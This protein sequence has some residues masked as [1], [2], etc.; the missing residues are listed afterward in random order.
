MANISLETTYEEA[1]EVLNFVGISQ[2]GNTAYY[3]YKEGIIVIWRDDSP[4]T[5]DVI[6]IRNSY[7]GTMDFGPWMGENRHIKMGQSFADQF[8]KGEE[9]TDILE[10][11]KARHFITSLYKH[12]ENTE[13]DCLETQS[14]SLSI[15]PEGIYVLF[16]FAKM[17]FLFGNDSRRNLVQIALIKDDDPA[18]FKSPFDMLTAQFFCE[19]EDGS[20]V[21]FGLGDSYKEVI[22]KS[23]INPDLPITYWNTLLAQQTKS[24]YIAWKRNNFE[25]KVEAIPDTTHLSLVHMGTNQYNIPFLLNQS[26]IKISLGEGN[27]VQLTLEPLAEEGT[28]WTM[29]DIS[30]KLQATEADSS[31]FYLSTEMPQIKGNI[32]VQKNL[33]KALLGLLEETYTNFYSSESSKLKIHKKIFGEYDDKFA[34]KPQGFLIISNPA[35]VPDVFLTKYPLEISFSIDEPSGRTGFAFSLVDDDFQNHMIKTPNDS[36]NFLQPVQELLGFKLGEKIY[37]RDKKPGPETAI[38]AYTVLNNHTTPKHP[39]FLHNLST[40][41]I[42]NSSKTLITLANY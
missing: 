29:Q 15:N 30:E 13:E 6:L 37:L 35:R 36:L 19:Q 33:I 3:V 34:L 17:V 9:H 5:P 31:D 12:L 16:H 7:Q 4:R 26:L 27:T 39:D 2:Q 23:G 38:V 28:Q 25:E 8:S 40:Y 41:A 24:T 32:T 42:P 18:C 22:E 1:Q 21:I 14:C 10:D 20:K 11:P